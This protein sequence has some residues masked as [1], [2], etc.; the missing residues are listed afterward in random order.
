VEIW[1]H[2]GWD[3]DV[4]RRGRLGLAGSGPSGLVAVRVP[5]ASSLSRIFVR[6][7]NRLNGPTDAISIQRKALRI[8]LLGNSNP[9]GDSVD[10]IYL[11]SDVAKPLTGS[12]TPVHRNA[13]HAGQHENRER[14][15]VEDFL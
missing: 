1:T 6:I 5:A 14:S 10:T 12:G 11:S 7:G 13:T 15:P 9:L 4:V 8:V 3:R 2:F